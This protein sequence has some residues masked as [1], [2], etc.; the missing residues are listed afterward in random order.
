MSTPEWL[1]SNQSQPSV[2]VT[3]AITDT[4]T[5]S[6][7]ALANNTSTNDPSRQRN[8]MEFLKHDRRLLIIT[9]LIIVFINVP[10][11]RW[12]VYPFTI[13]STYIH[14]V[15]HGMAAIFVGGAI[16]KILLYPDGSGLAYTYTMGT[17]SQGFVASA[18]Y[19]GTAAVGCFFLLFRR[20]KRGPRAGMMALGI[21]MILTVI[22][23]IRSVF[24]ILI[25][26]G[27]SVLF[28]LAA[29]KLPTGRIRDLYTSIAV[30]TVLNAITSVQALYGSNFVVNGQAS[31]TDAHT[32]AEIVGGSRILWATIWLL[33]AIVLTLVGLVFAIPGP[34][35]QPYFRCC[36]VFQPCFN[37]CNFQ[38][39]KP[40]EPAQ[41]DE[42]QLALV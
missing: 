42:G 35:E 19:Q 26:S 11:L 4:N 20:T 31:S 39:Q 8:C 21:F 22:L 29:W 34:D 27:M 3:P 9:L 24:G 30:T 5:S 15:C 33:L 25:V 2:G 17:K 23:W 1:K 7:S 37:L 10:F 32:M 18:G 28:C 41:D 6:N 13:F 16:Q 38:R 40:E 12:I 14:E 36:N